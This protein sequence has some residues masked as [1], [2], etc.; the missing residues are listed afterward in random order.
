[1]WKNVR[2]ILLACVAVML[3]V[4]TAHAVPKSIKLTYEVKRNGKLFGHV[5]ETYSQN[6]KQYKLQ[7]VTKGTGVYALLGER[8]LLSQGDVTKEGLRPKHFE[9]LQ[10]TSAKK[11]LINDF[12]W[13]TR[14]LSMQV[15]GEKQ[16]ETLVTGTQDLL[17]VMY[18]FM[19]KPPVPGPL[20]L[21]ITT[22]KR[23]KTHLYQVSA[24]ASPLVT[25]AGQ[26]KVVE[27]AE[28]EDEDAKKIYLAVDKYA[29]P[30][31]IVVQ[32]DGATFEQLITHITIE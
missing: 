6:G 10:S 21:P 5:K 27:L 20:K 28:K 15:K 1:M 31:K 26:F 12:D 24:Q 29:L 14:V 19:F 2:T 7:S 8:Q 3:V 25:D 4:Q 16:Q 23:L 11:T 22:G 13:K 32:D 9:S 17:S 18:Q 30:V